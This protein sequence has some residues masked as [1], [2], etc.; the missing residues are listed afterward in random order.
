[1]SMQPAIGWAILILRHETE[2]ERRMVSVNQ[3]ERSRSRAGK[4]AQEGCSGG[5]WFTRPA[6]EDTM[7]RLRD[8]RASRGVRVQRSNQ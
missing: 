1:M 5:E 4:G 7:Y 8:E 2:A 3:K 6:S